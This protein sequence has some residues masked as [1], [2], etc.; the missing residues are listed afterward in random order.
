MNRTV[1]NKYELL[2]EIGSGSFSKI[3]KVQDTYTNNYYAMK[4]EQ[5]PKPSETNGGNGVHPVSLIL[6]EANLHSRLSDIE[7]IPKMRWFGQD[8]LSYYMVLPL[9]KSTF[10]NV[11]YQLDAVTE[12]AAWTNVAQQMLRA[13][14]ALHQHAY[15]HRDIK[16]DNFMF[17]EEGKVFLIDLGM[18]KKYLTTNGH[19]VPHKRR[20]PGSILG[21]ANYISVNLHQGHEPSRRDDVESVCYVL[22]KICGGLDWGSDPD[23]GLASI[24]D[25]KNALLHHPGIPTPLLQLLQRTRNLNYFEEPCYLF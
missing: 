13:V 9:L 18:C 23:E 17:D 14:Q 20:P 1:L 16:P 3:Y 7:T 21:T 5:K 19:H 25:K 8:P 2:E 10:R 4:I 12:H 15:L 24:G 6:R 22:W 11:V